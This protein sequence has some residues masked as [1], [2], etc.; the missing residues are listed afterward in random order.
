[1]GVLIMGKEQV[2]N[3]E[4]RKKAKEKPKKAKKKYE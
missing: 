2:P 4:A 1:M 3:K